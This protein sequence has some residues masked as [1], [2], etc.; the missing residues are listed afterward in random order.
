MGNGLAAAGDNYD[1][2][3][4]YN[5]RDAETEAVHTH[6]MV[7]VPPPYAPIILGRGLKPKELWD[8]LVGALVS[9]G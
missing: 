9:D 7:F 5:P 8:Q 3:G 1:L 6:N 4:P 2:L